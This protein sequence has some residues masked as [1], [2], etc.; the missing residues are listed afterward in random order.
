MKVV[1][2]AGGRFHAHHL[3]QQLHQ[4]QS[5]LKLFTFDY[6]TADTTKVP[7]A[8]VTVMRSCKML[9]DLFISLRL[10]RIINKAHFNA[11][12]DNVFDTAV[13]KHIKKLGSFDLFI[14]WAH[15]ALKSIPLARASGATIIIESGSC[16]IATQQE[17]LSEEYKRWGITYNPI[18]SSTVEKMQ[19]EYASADYIMTLS[20]FARQSFINHGFTQHKILTIPCG[21][22]VDYFLANPQPSIKK[23]FIIICVGLVTLRKG[24]HHL[25]QAF[26]QANLPVADTQLVIVGPIQKDFSSIAAKL[27]IPA[28]VQ[29]I[30][31]VDRATLRTLYH[32]A[33]LFVLPS[34]EDGFGMV[35][36][37]AM[38]SSLP[39]I[40]STHSAGPDIIE[41]GVHGFLVP[42]HD[43]HDLAEKIQ[44]CYSNR[45]DAALMG[46]H[47][48]ERIQAFTWDRYGQQVYATY[49]DILAKAKTT[50][51]METT[52]C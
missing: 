23:K 24:I 14:G 50:K 37:E 21:V 29:F 18:C 6:T 31:S 22:D 49:R 2:S 15:Y 16:H 1:I 40:C 26:K 10:A 34:I 12:K 52:P 45:Y 36:G 42:P 32:Q 51:P 30:G 46:M 20:T 11:F 44:W 47:G 19:A 33:S 8:L 4:R 35:I 3:A 41:D 17:L 43:T 38:A 39:V 27:G 13:S 48:Q 7:P 25:V 5:L 9:N 28:N